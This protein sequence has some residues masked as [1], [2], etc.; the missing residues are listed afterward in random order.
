M[1]EDVNAQF[2]V[3]LNDEEAIKEIK[4]VAKELK[5]LE[6][7][8]IATG[9]KIR[10]IG[11]G[12]DLRQR[13]NKLS[14]QQALSVLPGS[15]GFNRER[16]RQES[17]LQNLLGGS[18]PPV[19]QIGTTRVSGPMLGPH[20]ESQTARERR[21][22]RERR[23]AREAERA[24]AAVP[25]FGP[26]PEAPS[27]RISRIAAEKRAQ[28]QLE[29]EQKR[30]VRESDARIRGETRQREEQEKQRR[31]IILDSEKQLQDQL[32]DLRSKARKAEREEE[33]KA[34]RQRREGD[35]LRKREAV[36]N[37]RDIAA[38]K[39]TI[40]RSLTAPAGIQTQ[41]AG[42]LNAPG[43]AFARQGMQNVGA[44]RS[45][46]IINQLVA[47]GMPL[48]QAIFL[49]AG[50]RRPP[51]LRPPTPPGGGGG[52]GFMRGLGR[53]AQS[54]A[55]G[56]L[57]VGLGYGGALAAVGAGR[58][59][60]EATETATAYDR[61]SVAAEKLA[62]SQEKLNELLNAYSEASG[63]AVDRST[64]LANVTRLLSTGFADTSEDV[65]RFVRATRGASIA[66]GKPQDYVIQETQLAISN[67]SVKR[68]DQIGLGIKEV[69]DRT[70]Q[71]RSV[72]K[73]WSREQA[74]QE[75]VISLMTQKYG[76]LTD[77]LEG[78]ATGL[79]RLRKA[80]ADLRLEMGQN[81]QG[82]VNSLAGGLADYF[83][84][85]TER[86]RLSQKFSNPNAQM[87]QFADQREREVFERSQRRAERMDW[88]SNALP[89]ALEHLTEA[90]LAS[91]GIPYTAPFKGPQFTDPVPAWMTG[92][93]S[94]AAPTNI[95]SIS[96]QEREIRTRHYEA[97]Q[98]L[99]RNYNRQRLAEVENYERQRE[100]I[101]IAYG[102]S[103]V[104]EEEDFARQ[105]ARSLR[106]YEKSIVDLMRDA[107][108]REAEMQEDLD[109]TIADAREDSNKRIKEIEEDY[110]KDQEKAEKKHRETLLKAA[111]QLD[112][113]A[114]LEERKRFAEENK[115][116]KE[117]HKEAVD[118]ARESL[119]E[120]IDE[121]KE[122]HEE[123]LEEAREADAERLRDMAADRKQ[124][125]ADEDEDRDIRNTRAAED[126]QE[127]LNELDRQHQDAMARIKREA[128]EQ[129][130][131]L[132]DAL[133]KD[134]EAAGA[135]VAGLTEKFISRDKMIDEWFD[136]VIERLEKE[137]KE[138]KESKYR[139]DP[140]LGPQ[141]P[142]SYASGGY[143]PRTGIAMLHAGEY[144]VPASQVASSSSSQYNSDSR[145]VQIHA[146]A[147]Q[148]V[149]TPGYEHLV[150]ELVEEQ[151]IKL[152]ERV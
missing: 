56:I 146:G 75:A 44:T 112:A 89:N 90:I 30:A 29:S 98:D 6:A 113:I 69:T 8:A 82:P 72:N 132:E 131:L 21:E 120:Q 23:L 77:T 14:P 32:E 119:Q 143:V 116:R 57:G 73:E 102:K 47:G 148:V 51:A 25:V 122:A 55:G 150:G 1:A 61:Q 130:Q 65:S 129:T 13:L 9:K 84:D 137:I 147:I 107:A 88:L 95:S 123:R 139:Y 3:G 18:Q 2:N 141:I 49:G 80:W 43:A 103:V 10:E 17:R 142:D 52:G 86:D 12:G 109:E 133:I 128:D 144:V 68:L 108:K 94:A 78:Q 85:L 100:S 111:G 37:A 124:Q 22:S 63:G 121:A 81:A 24:A 126:H 11:L 83:E 74:F 33:L 115:E 40:D 110:R 101:I 136:K 134:L 5:A 54:A 36:Q 91:Q 38:V 127:Q 125:L 93:T 48:Q 50:G 60:I 59:V 104:R 106:D 70:E 118:D 16:Q 34:N 19:Q 96:D 31:R 58:A 41:V 26:M 114:I 71:L 99:E 4:S 138:E 39:R 42:I 62:G 28:E 117:S 20:P 64:E 140:R 97:I 145:M 135:Y 87:S 7:Q 92:V 66:L 79:E 151:M 35:V 45:Q 76:G 53:F 46:S 15:S 152:L 67:T 105:R 27:A 149:T